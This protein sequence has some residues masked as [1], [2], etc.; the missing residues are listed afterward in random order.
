MGKLREYIIHRLQSTFKLLVKHGIYHTTVQNKT[1]EDYLQ[2]IINIQS[3]I[4][5]L[6]KIK[7]YGS[8]GMEINI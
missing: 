4:E 8:K 7:I 1:D 6:G 2:I 5:L 3:S